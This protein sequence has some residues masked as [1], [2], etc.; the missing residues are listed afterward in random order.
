[1]VRVLCNLVGMMLIAMMALAGAAP[2]RARALPAQLCIA[3][4]AGAGGWQ[5][6]NCSARN[7]HG[8]PAQA[9]LRLVPERGS[10]PRFL[11]TRLGRFGSMTAVVI[12]T[13]GSR[14]TRRFGE[15]D[16]AGVGEGW[17]MRATLPRL[18]VPTAA[19]E[20]TVVY[21]RHVGILVEAALDDGGPPS[22]GQLRLELT[23]AALCGLLCAPFLFN[24][25][26]WRVLRQRFL[27]WHTLA[28]ACML[29]QTMVTSGLINR[30][31]TLPVPVLFGLGVFSLATGIAFAALFSSG[32]I[33]ED[34]LDPRHR[35]WLVATVLWLALTSTCY[36]FASG[37]LATYAPQLYYGSYL[38]V[39][40]V[41]GWTMAVAWTRGSRAVRFQLAAWLPLFLLSAFR[42]ASI[43]GATA[44]PLDLY[45]GQHVAI[46]AEILITGF[47]VV[48]RFMLMRE[49]RDSALVETRILGEAVDRDPLTGLL[50]RRALEARFARYYQKGFRTVAV[51]DLDQFKLVNDRFGHDVGD[52]VLRAVAKALAP[53]DDTRAIRLGGEE[54]MLLLR[55]RDAAA[56]A[57][58][59][60]N[61]IPLRIAAEVPGLDRVVTASMGLVEQAAGAVHADFPALYAHCDRL[62]YEAKRTGRNRTMAER[63]QNFTDRRG[64]DRRIPE[65]VAAA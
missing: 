14:A 36:L 34:K 8:V 25:A 40:A 53:D 26:F 47:G 61:A 50:N 19:V 20:V 57:E 49:Q 27:I 9:R 24:F 3:L 10:D 59:R 48:D 60:R 22:A 64:S 62:L 65:A 33:E 43:L 28:V 37:P 5:D 41:L 15:A 32:F 12:G 30:L 17:T 58:Q 51:I 63:L 18:A 39:M 21:P 55:G 6:W 31:V 16:F 38:P 7:W 44:A 52:K 11:T 23:I 54:F 13:D 46:I 4:P 2:A 1:M 29:V 42:I 45:L 35:R 56:R